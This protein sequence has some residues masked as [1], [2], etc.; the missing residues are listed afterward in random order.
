MIPVAARLVDKD[1]AIHGLDFIEDMQIVVSF[2]KAEAIAE[3]KYPHH[4]FISKF[5]H[6]SAAENATIEVWDGS[7]AYSYLSSATTLYLSS[8]DTN[9]DQV[10][11]VFG[12]DADWEEQMVQVTAN[13]FV[14]VVLSSTWIRVFRVRNLG[15][16]DNAGI[17]Y[18]STDNDAGG[19][20]VPDTQSDI[21]AQISVG[22]NQTLMAI[23][24]VPNKTN[25][26]FITNFYASMSAA[27]SKTA[28]IGLWVRPFGGVFQVKKIFSIN[29]GNTFQLKYDFALPVEGKSDI[30]VTSNASGAAEISA[31]FDLWYEEL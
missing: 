17:I 16:T 10:Y 5:G 1:G 21:K 6:D 30:K 9:D 19:D 13:G 3:G 28:E 11:E 23:W 24:S 7:F 14:S 15:T 29:S 26:A 27:T 22:M 20:G 2:P 4:K 31:G 12:L 8:S 18:V 25:R